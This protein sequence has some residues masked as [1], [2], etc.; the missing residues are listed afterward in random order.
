MKKSDRL[1]GIDSQITRRDFIGSAMIGAGATLLGSSSPAQQFMKKT[2]KQ[3]SDPWTG[4]GGIGDYA[5]SNGNTRSVM[6]DSHKLRDQEKAS[7]LKTAT[8]TEEEFDLVVVGGGFSGLGAAYEFQAKSEGRSCLVLDNHPVFGGEAKENEF[9]VDGYRL[10]GPQGSNGFAVPK[11]ISTLSDEVYRTV[12]MPMDYTFADKKRTFGLRTPY[13][14]YDAMF[15]GENKFDIGYYFGKNKNEKWVKNI[16]EDDLKRTPWSLQLKKDM[17]R[18]FKGKESAHPKEGLGAWLDSMTY[19]DY[20]E[21]Q[22]GLDPGVTNHL[23][24]ILAIANYGFGCDVISAYGAYLI[25][26]PGMQGYLNIDPT[27]SLSDQKI[28]SF[29]GGNTTYLRHI[30]KHLIPKAIPGNSFEEI[31]YNKINFAALDDV[32]SSTRIRLGATGIDVNETGDKVS[33][34]YYRNG[35][36]ERITSKAVVM[37]TAGFMAKNVVSSMPSIIHDNYDQFKHGPALVVNVALKN[38]KFLERLGFT[39]GRWYDGFGYFGSIRAPM[40]IGKQEIPFHPKK[41]MVMTFYVPF[42]YPGKTIDEQGTMGRGELLGKIY[43]DFEREIRM[44]MNEIFGPGGFDAK[45]DIAGIILNRW[46]HAYVSPQP[47]FYFGEA[48][49]GGLA[50]PMKKGHGRVFYGHSELGSR[51]NY[52]N[53]ISEGGRAGSQ[54][55]SII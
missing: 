3:Y 49:G 17:I 24:P 39:A 9:E 2:G 15:W 40:N 27:S 13:D 18:A 19:K 4:Y 26:L 29:P 14:S 7:L 51:M 37:A 31:A 52:R 35:K 20:L 50:D 42:Y 23:D 28:F 32:G 33:I 30:V 46:G 22:L 48:N 41:P 47:G 44:H 54:A 12:G 16:W 55:A 5:S 45:K 38:W 10:F 1:L 53:A 11:G 36:A 34:V 6:L 43:L 25:A 21:K 8:D